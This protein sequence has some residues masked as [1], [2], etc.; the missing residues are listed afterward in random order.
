MV[1]FF[2]TLDVRSPSFTFLGLIISSCCFLPLSAFNVNCISL[3]SPGDLFLAYERIADAN[4]LFTDM[5]TAGSINMISDSAAQ[6]TML[7]QRHDLTRTV[8]FATFGV[9]DGGLTH[10]WL[11][12]LDTLL[13]ENNGSPLQ[14]LL[15]VAADACVYTPLF[16]VWFLSAFVILEGRPTKTIPSVVR[17]NFLEL[18]QGNLKFYLPINI[19]VYGYVPKD[20]RVL[21]FGMGSIIYTALLSLWNDERKKKV[22]IRATQ[23]EFF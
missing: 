5:I 14:T 22:Q 20:E 19:L 13:G 8:R 10:A 11:F 2:K 12:S 9:L 6:A 7:K 3:S 18:V 17:N 16:C 15:K 1:L 4:S 21:A 23:N